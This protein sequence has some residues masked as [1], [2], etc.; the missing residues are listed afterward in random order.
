MQCGAS[1]SLV[2]Q[3][4]NV[5]WRFVYVVVGIFQ[6]ANDAVLASTGLAT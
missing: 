1:N 5:A 4:V 3:S 6:E 2:A